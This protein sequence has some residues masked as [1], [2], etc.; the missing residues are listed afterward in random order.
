MA[1]TLSISNR[2]A[3]ASDDRSPDVELSVVVPIFDEQDNIASLC[4]SLLAVLDE[5]PSSF[6]IIAVNDGS[7]DDSLDRLKAEA[8]QR[9][10][11]KVVDLRRNYGQTAALMAGIDHASGTIL[12]AIDGDLQN[13]PQDIPALLDKLN[14]GYDVVSGWRVD[15]NH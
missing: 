3:A 15:R 7:R 12:V 6:E 1:K 10:E 13:D 4:Q 14:E 2:R 9:P 11:I 5:L 8:R